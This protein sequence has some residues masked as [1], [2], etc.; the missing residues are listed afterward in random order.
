MLSSLLLGSIV[1]S[2]GYCGKSIYDIIKPKKNISNDEITI[3]GNKL[4][5]KDNSYNFNELFYNCGLDNKSNDMP[6]LIEYKNMSTVDIFTFKL[7]A[8]VSV[9]KVRTKLE[10]VAD[11]FEVD[12][13]NIK[14]QKKNNMMDIIITR[15]NLFSNDKVIKYY[16]P[17]LDKYK[18]IMPL[19]HFINK[20]YIEEFLSVDMSSGSIPHALIASTT[21]GGK[22]NFVRSILLSWF[23]NYSPKELQ[24]YIIDS[25]GG[26][27]YTTLLYAPHVIDNVCYT[28]VDEVKGILDECLIEIKERNLKLI[29]KEVI[30]CVEYRQKGL[31]MPHKVILIDEYASFEDKGKSG[32]KIEDKVNII[33]ANGRKVGVH[34]II[35][36]QDANKDS[37]N[38]TV[39]RNLPLKIGFKADN[40]QHSKNICNYTGLETLKV[41]GVGRAYGLPID[42]QYV[43]FR[44]MLAP[45][46]S[47][48]KSMIK[49]K[50]K[51]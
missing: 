11:F 10:E 4:T 2:I 29:K 14:I 35:V 39:K 23:M 31:S 16:T 19:G 18:L 28:D 22:S 43:Q 24:I 9:S 5:S 30:N 20:D 1:G 3:Q 25:Q 26:A 6:Q 32:E 15:S 45:S 51:L 17:K 8:G 21:G 50:Y 48:I 38:P 34:V 27:D 12:E 7:P 41:K 40:E 36:T 47:K 46:S 42:D 44:A 37:L 33:A 49:E 13:M